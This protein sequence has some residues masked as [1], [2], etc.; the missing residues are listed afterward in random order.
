MSYKAP[1]TTLWWKQCM[2][3]KNFSIVT[4]IFFIHSIPIN[5]QSYASSC[6]MLWQ[7]LNHTQR[8]TQ[9][10]TLAMWTNT[11]CSTCHYRSPYIYEPMIFLGQM[12]PYYVSLGWCFFL[13]QVLPWRS[14]NH[15]PTNSF[16]LLLLLLCTKLIAMNYYKLI[17]MH[18]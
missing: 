8:F 6:F 11:S 3:K 16:I 12:D 5:Y 14:H 18:T 1:T 7:L 15:I 17:S 4:F 9:A 10:T 13:H 2:V